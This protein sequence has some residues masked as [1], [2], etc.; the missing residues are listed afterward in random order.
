MAGGALLLVLLVLGWS[1]TA[2]AGEANPAAPG[3]PPSP[4]VLLA[5]GERRVAERDFAG[6][7]APLREGIRLTLAD[8]AN[9]D[10]PRL[11]WAHLTLAVAELRLGND[12]AARDA[13]DGAVRLDPLLVLPE[14][15]YPAVVEREL[16]RARMRVSRAGLGELFIR[17]PEGARAFVDGRPVG[18]VPARV[19]KL[20]LGT[21]YVRAETADGRVLARAVAV[22]ARPVIVALEDEPAAGV[23]PAAGVP[24]NAPGVAHAAP[25]A[26]TQVTP[27]ATPLTRVPW[28]GW[29]GGAVVVATVATIVVVSLAS[30]PAAPQGTVVAT[31]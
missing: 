6:A 27:P 28:W 24:A 1:T 23:V 22:A 20:P 18:D 9:A 11:V 13:M 31:W 30:G 12:T 3:T 8:H 5:E 17:T 15:S 10:F 25:P 29:A 26:A 2:R 14:G 19:F 21:H 16:E 7:I 4:M